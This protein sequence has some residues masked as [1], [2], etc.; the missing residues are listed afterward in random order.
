MR[1]QCHRKVLRT[2]YTLSLSIHFE[3]GLADSTV[4]LVDYNLELLNAFVNR[5]YENRVIHQVSRDGF[6]LIHWS[7]SFIILVLQAAF[8]HLNKLLVTH[9]SILVQVEMVC[10]LINIVLS[11]AVG[12]E[13]VSHRL[14]KISSRNI[15]IVASVQRTECTLQVLV[16]SVDL[17]AH[18]LHSLFCAKAWSILAGVATIFWRFWRL[19]DIGG[20][21]SL[22]WFSQ[23]VAIGILFWQLLLR[24]SLQWLV[25]V[26]GRQR[27]RPL[28]PHTF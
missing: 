17:V 28:S 4:A 16:V 27:H 18:G 12:Q 1:Q 23:R 10:H 9:A 2:E 11:E 15:A 26:V 22:E 7:W 8:D 19:I 6:W 3:E 24:C 13:N 25:F 5:G 20:I 21:R 14:E